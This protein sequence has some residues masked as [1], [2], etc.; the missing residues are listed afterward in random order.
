[1]W[2]VGVHFGLWH[3]ELIFFSSMQ[4]GTRR[5][6]TSSFSFPFPVKNKDSLHLLHRKI[7]QRSCFLPSVSCMERYVWD[8][9]S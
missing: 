3:W 7:C 9:G 2:L 1:M 6:H 4:I 8:R 5:M